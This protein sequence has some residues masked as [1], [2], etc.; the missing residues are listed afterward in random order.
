MNKFSLLSE[1]LKKHFDNF[2]DLFSPIF[3]KSLTS[4]ETMKNS[5]FVENILEEKISSNENIMY[6]R[7]IMS[8]E[9]YNVVWEN[10]IENMSLKRIHIISQHLTSNQIQNIPT[11]ILINETITIDRIDNFL[12]ILPI[13][14][15]PYNQELASILKNTFWTEQKT[16][17]HN[18]WFAQLIISSEKYQIIWE[19]NLLNENISPEKMYAIEEYLTI[20]QITVI[21]WLFLSHENMTVDKIILIGQMLSADEILDI[22]AEN[23]AKMTIGEIQEI[24]YG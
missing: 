4:F 22:W 7:L 1:E 23:L 21:S 14:T 11:H 15:I 2:W 5:I 6:A 12:K 10:N 13:F 16:V 8:P 19:E 17:E 18:I 3:K 24:L 9:I 20:E